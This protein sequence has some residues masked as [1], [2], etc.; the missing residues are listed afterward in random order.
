MAEVDT[1]TP[2]KEWQAV[3][4]KALTASPNV[5]G[6]ARKARV[7]RQSAYKARAADPD[8]RAAWDNA[9]GSSIENAEGEM[10]RRA[11]KGTITKRH[12][13]KEGNLLGVDREYSDTLL[14]FLLKAHKP[15]VYRETTRNE[16]S[17]SLKVTQTHDLSK[18]SLDELIQLRAI[19]SK[20][21]EDT[22]PA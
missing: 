21:S 9:L 2:K 7:S 5:A 17:G 20:T 3:F 11:V 14:I 19:V 12:Y 15:E 8:F 10:Y 18:L 16:V 6:A 1:L 4:L 13:S 22:E